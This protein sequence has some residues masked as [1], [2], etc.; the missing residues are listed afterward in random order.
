M[1]KIAFVYPG[2]G[3]QKVGMGK[4][5]Y[6]NSERSK[7]I[8]DLAASVL[9][10]DIKQVCFEENDFINNT[11][12]TQ[13]AL[14]TTCLAMTKEVLALGIKPDVTAGLSLGEYAAIATAGGMSDEEAIKTV[15]VRGI[16]MDEAVPDGKGAMAAV[17]GMTGEAV[18]EVVKDLA[19]V[20][21]ANYN[22]P[23]Q[24]VITGEKSAVENAGKVLSENG[25]K[26]VIP[27]NVS[28]PFHS[29]FLKGA[30]ETLG[31]TLETVDWKELEIGYVTN[32][33]ASLV[34][35]IRQTKDLLMKQVSSSVLWEQSVRNMIEMGVDTFVEIGPGKT[36]AGF[37]KKID[38]EV[39]VV[40]VGAF[41][42]LAKLKEQ[43]C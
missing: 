22:C 36:L 9:D 42:D 13:A 27:L 8:F 23:G 30:G 17:L 4:D 20:S 14:V 38:K 37:I 10:F 33:D 34:T 16:L 18:Y 12:Y 2:Q 31:E 26:R 1:G 40:N 28:G 6:E 19:D 15:R 43:L 32:V 5:F 29:A 41:E 3:A 11:K 24:I 21:I 39:Q 7:E 25:A 35:D